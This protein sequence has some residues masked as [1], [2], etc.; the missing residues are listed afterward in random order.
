MA[1]LTLAENLFSRTA[2]SGRASPSLKAEAEFGLGNL[3]EL[4]ASRD[5]LNAGESR[6]LLAEAATHY[7]KIF[8]QSTADVH[9]FW[10]KKS[11]LSAI[12][13]MTRNGDLQ[14]ASR[15]R[16]RFLQMFP[17]ESSLLQSLATGNP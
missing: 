1:A 7:R 12:S 6:R 13:L 3:K 17:G 15:A 4:R 5:S 10:I 8:Y 2:G 14:Q 9:P 11:G 16:Q